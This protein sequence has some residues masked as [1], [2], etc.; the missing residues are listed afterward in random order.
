M[1]FSELSPKIS[2]ISSFAVKMT[3]DETDLIF[4]QMGFRPNELS[5]K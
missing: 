2:K 5:T 3:Y 4:G 1:E